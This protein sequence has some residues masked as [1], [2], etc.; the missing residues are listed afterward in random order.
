MVVT[1]TTSQ[2][3]V[4]E[5]PKKPPL[6]TAP[7]NDVIKASITQPSELT[8]INATRIIKREDSRGVSIAGRQ[9]LWSAPPAQ[10]L[11]R[12][13]AK[14]PPDTKAIVETDD[15]KVRSGI[16]AVLDNNTSQDK[17]TSQQ[18]VSHGGVNK[19]ALQKFPPKQGHDAVSGVE[20]K[21]D[22]P[23]TGPKSDMIGATSQG[24]PHHKSLPLES[25][26][27]AQHADKAL[28]FGGVTGLGL[29]P[30]GTIVTHSQYVE[31]Q[32]EISSLRDSIDQTRRT[33]DKR[34]VDL[35][36]EIDDEKKT[37]LGLQVEIERLRKYFRSTD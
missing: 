13:V 21:R 22:N 28:S 23:T 20:I 24:S 2:T 11:E 4:E 33:H 29:P 6:P 36:S 9:A 17:A 8:A 3:A 18:S 37:R 27:A 14:I 10:N 34:F 15:Q 1:T 16:V 25:R 5:K 32:K 12:K 30:A 7:P 31:L 19:F 26:E 35:M